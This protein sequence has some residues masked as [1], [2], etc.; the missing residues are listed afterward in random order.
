M[1]QFAFFGKDVVEL[2]GCHSSLLGVSK[3]VSDVFTLILGFSL[4]P[5]FFIWSFGLLI[6]LNFFFI[7]IPGC[8]QKTKYP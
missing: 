6:Y 3:M 5:I 1:S 7:L 2:G 4:L 8:G